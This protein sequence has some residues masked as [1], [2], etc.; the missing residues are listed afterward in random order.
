MA[1]MAHCSTLWGMYVAPEHRRAKLGRRLIDAAIEAARAMPEVERI[2]LSV[3]EQNP[4]AQA[5]YRAA[6]FVA[7]GTERDAFRAAGRA[8]DEVHMVLR[9][10]RP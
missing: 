7:W 6:G 1:K 9:L 8:V 4:H 10:E 3:D 5:L 2:A